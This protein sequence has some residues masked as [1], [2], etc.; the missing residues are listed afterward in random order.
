M[1]H[2]LN[3]FDI[4]ILFEVYILQ[5]LMALAVK[6]IITS[7]VTPSDVVQSFAK[8]ALQPVRRRSMDT[9]P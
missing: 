4:L 9:I 6:I 3:V 7:D 1:L 8:C 5:V 2:F